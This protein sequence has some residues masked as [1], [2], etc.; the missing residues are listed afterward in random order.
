MNTLYEL[1]GGLSPATV[2]ALTW[3]LHKE[4]VRAASLRKPRAQVATPAPQKV[5]RWQHVADLERDIWDRTFHHEDVPCCCDGCKPKPEPKRYPVRPVP[6][7]DL[8][9]QKVLTRR[10]GATEAGLRQRR[11]D[12]W[13]QMKALAERGLSRAM[14]AEE[15]ARW[16]TLNAQLDDLDSRLNVLITRRTALEALVKLTPKDKSYPIY[17]EARRSLPRYGYGFTPNYIEVVTLGDKNRIYLPA[18]R[19]TQDA[20]DYDRGRELGR[21]II[22]QLEKEHPDE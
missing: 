17:Q 14:T 15:Q 18:D 20:M 9:P 3:L 6:V 16:E 11:L 4:A 7:I 12:L 10:S 8:E 1:I 22:R 5:V 21:D 13:T 2:L 19:E